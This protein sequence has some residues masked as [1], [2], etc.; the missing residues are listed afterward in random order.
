MDVALV[1]K[2]RSGPLLRFRIERRLSQ[3]AAAVLAEVHVDTWG[4]LER[5]QF[6]AGRVSPCAIAKVAVL[7][8]VDPEEIAPAELRGKCLA[9]DRT[10]F[11][12]WSAERLTQDIVDRSLPSPDHAAITAEL[13]G[14]VDQLM[15][16]V[17]T[18]RERRVLTMRWGLGD[19]GG[20]THTLE[21]PA[22][23]RLP[24]IDDNDPGPRR[25]R[26]LE[27]CQQ[28][29]GHDKRESVRRTTP[30]IARLQQLMLR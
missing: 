27:L 19:Y 17:L 18:E 2:V 9:L 1:A 26:I 12:E 24:V 14:A 6:G 21:I 5:L 29:F 8:D 3:A 16:D 25:D 7:L 30:M 15:R 22:R 10:V 13:S 20:R 28:L 11:A 4:A 23:S